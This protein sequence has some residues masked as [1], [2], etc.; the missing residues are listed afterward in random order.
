MTLS[1]SDGV[2]TVFLVDDH[3]VF[4]SGV[5]AE[6]AGEDGLS[7]AGEAGTV[8]ESID[9]IVATRPDVVLLDVHMPGGG[10]VA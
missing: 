7:I 6:L 8:P 1:D 10:G 4:R 3:A 9:R 5:R 2:C